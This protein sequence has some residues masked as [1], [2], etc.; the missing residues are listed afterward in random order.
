LRQIIKPL[1]RTDLLDQFDR[2]KSELSGAQA[3]L[4][5]HPS[6]IEQIEQQQERSSIAAVSQQVVKMTAMAQ[7]VIQQKSSA[8]SAWGDRQLEQEVARTK[9]NGILTQL[10]VI[11]SQLNRY[12][13]EKAKYGGI[14]VPPILE[15]TISDLEQEVQQLESD[16][17]EARRQLSVLMAA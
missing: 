5:E 3:I 14:S 2:I 7:E 11:I 16:A 8:V 6:T 9:L 17:N 1:N 12:K 15:N 10:N 13:I 4:T